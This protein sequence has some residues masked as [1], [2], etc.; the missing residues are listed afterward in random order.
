VRGE[1][2]TSIKKRLDNV[3]DVLSSLGV[4]PDEH[5]ASNAAAQLA[6]IKDAFK[7][8]RKVPVCC[9]SYDNCSRI[10]CDVHGPLDAKQFMMKCRQCQA[11]IKQTLRF[12]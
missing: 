12:L 8:S 2:F 1:G 9:F 4:E 7:E 6:V 11:Q 5:T 10:I 3:L